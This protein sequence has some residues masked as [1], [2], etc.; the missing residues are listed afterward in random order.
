[1]PDDV[2]PNSA[3]I[4][5]DFNEPIYTNIATTTI[6]AC[7]EAFDYTAPTVT[8]NGNV[9][10]ASGEGIFHWMINGEVLDETDNSIV[11]T[12]SG[13]YSVYA[14]ST[15]CETN[16]SEL[17]FYAMNNNELSS[18]QIPAVFPNPMTFQ[19]TFTSG[20]RRG[21]LIITDGLGNEVLR[22]V[23][24]AQIPFVIERSEWPA[25]LYYL[26]FE[27]QGSIQC[28]KLMVE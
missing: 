23:I 20:N 14:S 9:L 16:L 13:N 6:Y 1:L 15:G 11:I 18:I 26:R 27:M 12:E 4:Y 22:T 17:Q 21:D 7:D 24:R 10:T 8:Q 19:S 5:F 25:G 3:A 28:L 2:I